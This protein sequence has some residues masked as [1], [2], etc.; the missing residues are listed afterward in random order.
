MQ[1]TFIFSDKILGADFADMRL[2]NKSNKGAEL[3]KCIIDICNKYKWIV[4]W[5]TRKQLQ[6]PTYFKY[7]LDE[8]GSISNKIWI[9]Q[10]SVLINYVEVVCIE[11]YSTHN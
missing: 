7:F 1:V 2:T 9:D 10:Q 6:S 8:S 5:R 3:F 4:L 11:I